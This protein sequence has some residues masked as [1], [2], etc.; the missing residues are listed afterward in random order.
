MLRLIL[1]LPRILILVLRR[2]IWAAIDAQQ[3]DH[4]PLDVMLGLD[5]GPAAAS[6]LFEQEIRE[7]QVI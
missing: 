2:L 5:C 4:D 7:D 3:R 1:L 6:A